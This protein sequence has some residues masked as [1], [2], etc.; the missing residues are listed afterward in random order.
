[1]E[2]SQAVRVETVPAMNREDNT[3]YF[4]LA[5]GGLI[6]TVVFGIWWFLPSH[7]PHNFNGTLH[8]FDYILFII[9]SYIVWYQ[10]IMEILSWYLSLNTKIPISLPAPNNLKVALV[11]A[12]VPG[13]ESYGILEKTLK[14]MIEVDY[15][16][17][18]W[19]LDEGND[20]YAKVLCFKYGVKYFTRYG[21]RRYNQPNGSFKAKTKAGNYNAWFINYSGYYEIVAQHDVDFV[22]N[23][24]FLTKTLGYFR[25]PQIAFVGAPQIYG[26][27]DESWIVRGAAEQAFSFYGPIQKGLFGAGM[28]LFIGAIHIVRVA[29]YNTIGGY[30]GHIVEDHITGMKIYAQRWKSVYVPEIL[31]V[32]EGPATWDAYFSQQMRWAYGLIDILFRHSPKIFSKMRFKHAVNYFMLQQHYFNGLIQGIGVLLLFIYFIYGIEATSMELL[33]LVLLYTPL[34]IIQLMVFYFLQRLYID[35]K[36]ETGWLGKG[37]LLSMAAWPIYLV[38]FFSVL[39]NKRL[40]YKV[41]PKGDL[42]KSNI[43]LRLFIPHIILGSLT[44]VG[45]IISF[46]THN[47]APQL[48]FFALLNSVFMYYF[49]FI[50]VKDQFEVGWLNSMLNFIL[51]T[52]RFELAE[53][54][55]EKPV[56]I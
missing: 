45:I 14:S 21:I 39:L 38:A 18:T 8:I 28:Q 37:K 19:L 27:Q 13:K 41:T 11:T 1:M 15:P 25:D 3:T 7:I 17:D 56:G 30:C 16:H 2:N 49:V 54:K 44:T 53:S 4:Y 20:Y 5:I 34:L 24:D 29:A 43:D 55:S 36:T 26:N 35:P 10:I 42:Q 9:L 46:F 6:I 52:P 51:G 50:A 22:P 32:G 31:A 47:Q 48:I 12:F 33:G 40:T 23:K